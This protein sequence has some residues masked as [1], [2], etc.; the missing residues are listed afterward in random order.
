MLH[1]PLALA[2]NKQYSL[3]NK[4]IEILCDVMQSLLDLF[5]ITPKFKIS[6]T[7][8]ISILKVDFNLKLVRRK[9]SK[10]C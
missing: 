5:W 4:I 2:F 7:A 6:L 1:L 9:I 3:M 8:A 10:K